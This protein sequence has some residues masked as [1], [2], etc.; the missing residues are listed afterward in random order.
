MAMADGIPSIQ[1]S[2]FQMSAIHIDRGTPSKR[3][4]G[5]RILLDALETQQR[6]GF[7]DII[8]GD[9]SLIYLHMSPNSIWIGAEE[10]ASIRP[11]TTIVSTKAMLTMF[12]GIHGVTLVDWLHQDSSFNMAYFD[13]HI[14]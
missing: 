11:R 2:A 3:V 10:T 7:R 6:I 1:K 8:T 4:D 14:L 13:E 9:E 5:A 12:W